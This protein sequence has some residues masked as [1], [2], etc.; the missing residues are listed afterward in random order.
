[1]AETLNAVRSEFTPSNKESVR[2]FSCI[3]SQSKVCLSNKKMEHS[4]GRRKKNNI[5]SD[6]VSFTST[7]NISRSFCVVGVKESILLKKVKQHFFKF[8]T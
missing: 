3:Y 5:L 8:K 7:W 1:M 6:I 2:F 4:C